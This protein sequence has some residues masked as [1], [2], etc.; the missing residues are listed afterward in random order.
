MGHRRE[1]FNA[2]ARASVA[3]GQQKKG[4]GRDKGTGLTE[5]ADPNASIIIPKSRAEK[6][7][8]KERIQN[9]VCFVVDL[10]VDYYLL[11]LVNARFWKSA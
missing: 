4:K 3:G 9:D 8:D 7:A 1:R 2:K 10:N 5:A 6:T 11:S